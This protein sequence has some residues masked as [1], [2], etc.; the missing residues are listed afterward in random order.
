M[1]TDLTER[2]Q[3]IA[4]ARDVAESEIL[5]QALERGVEDLWIDLVLSRYVNDEIDRETAIDLVGR[6]RV[7]R[8]ERELQ[9][10]EDDV[11]WGLSA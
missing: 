4:E 8:A 1:A 5:E 2:V 10:V 7:K 6:D 9:V 11:Q 3:E